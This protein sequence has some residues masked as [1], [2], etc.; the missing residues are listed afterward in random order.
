M[1]HGVGN[2]IMI[3]I[4][5]IVL[6]IRFV[7]AEIVC[8]IRNIVQ[9]PELRHLTISLTLRLQ[10]WLLCSLRWLGLLVWNS[11]SRFYVEG[12]TIRV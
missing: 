5:A 3:I 4:T 8:E 1:Q 12:S 7:F 6:L 11:N 10:L 9:I 2:A